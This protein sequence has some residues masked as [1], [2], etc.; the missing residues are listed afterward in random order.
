MSER[1]DEPLTDAERL[2]LQELKTQVMLPTFTARER[3]IALTVY[4]TMS[5]E[6]SPPEAMSE[7][8]QALEAVRGFTV[9][10]CDDCLHLR[11]EMCH[12]ANCRFCRRTM[13]EVAEYLDVLLIRPV[14]DG[15]SVIVDY[16]QPVQSPPVGVSPQ[17]ER[18]VDPDPE[19]PG[20]ECS[21]CSGEYC[22][23]H[24]TDPCDCDVAARHANDIGKPAPVSPVEPQ[25][26]A[27]AGVF[28]DRS[29]SD[30]E[31]ACGVHI[32]EEQ[33]KVLPNTALIALLCDAVRCSRE[34][35]E[36]RFR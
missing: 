14:I 18:F 22:D 35:A 7:R 24:I 23:V 3:E 4:R 2:E 13:A 6:P 25:P 9:Y 34:L 20:Q 27:I 32:A 21:R 16:G 29:V 17:Q 30:F 1:E 36:K 11:G 12:E 8:G 31:R 5:V 26:A 33:R 28:M 15:V 10:I 19:C